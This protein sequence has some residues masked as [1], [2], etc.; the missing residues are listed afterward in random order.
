MEPEIGSRLET[1][2]RK[3][4]TGRRHRSPLRGRPFGPG[5]LLF[6]LGLSQLS[7]SG[8]DF[9]EARRHA[10]KALELDASL[11]EAHASLGFVK[12]YFDWDW[13]GAEAEFQR[14]ITLDPNRA[15]SHQWYSIFLL[16]AG[17]PAEALQE[18]QLAQQRDPLSLP[19][20]TDLGFCYYYTGRY[21]EA[22]KQ[23]NLV[24][25]MDPNF[26]SAH[27]WLGRAYQEL[28]QFDEAAG[29]ISPGRGP[30]PRLARFDC[31]DGD[32]SP[33]L[34]GRQRAGSRG[35][36]RVGKA[37]GPQVCDVLR[38]RARPCRTRSER[39]RL[40]L[41]QQSLR[42]EVELVGMVAPRSALERTAPRSTICAPREPH[43]ISAVG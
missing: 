19:V 15:A 30:H 24:L 27:L 31:S 42:R 14:A 34:S 16:T 38:R 13:S 7:L 9:P 36:C 28:G 10:N 41:A 5:G 39:G 33:V 23:L 43:A 40:C 25:E 18:I 11:A 3:V 32:S 17:R 8:R 4:S 20:N 2:D 22:V 12:L 26:P 37:V 35:A 1:R 21:D 29:R 6:G